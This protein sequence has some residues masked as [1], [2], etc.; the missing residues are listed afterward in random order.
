MQILN[1]QHAHLAQEQLLSSVLHARVSMISLIFDPHRRQ[2][3]G[4]K[5]ASG[6]LLQPELLMPRQTHRADGID[7][8]R[9]YSVANG[10]LAR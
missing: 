6:T 8:L 4:R 3:T 2:G 9:E 7:L 10:P 1:R 5:L